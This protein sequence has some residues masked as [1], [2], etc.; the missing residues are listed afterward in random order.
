MTRSLMLA[1]CLLAAGCTAPFGVRH[2]PPEAMH[3]ALNANVLTT[4]ELSNATDIMLRQHDLIEA[5][6][7]DPAGTLRLLNSELQRGALRADDLAALAELSFHYADHGGGKPQFLAA[8]LYAYAFLFPADPRVA[9]DPLDPRLRETADL[10]SRSLTEAFRSADGKQVEIAAGT[11]ALPFGQLDVTFDDQQLR[12]GD[13]RLVKFSPAE[14]L[15]VVGFRNRYRQPGIG[16]PLAAAT[17]PLAPIDPAQPFVVGPHVRVPVTLLLRVPDP[18]Q[19]I[20]GTQ[21]TALL[22]LHPATVA[23]STEIDERTVALAQ[24]PTAALALALNES[25]PWSAELAS[26]LGQVLQTPVLTGKLGG[27][28]PHRQGRIP[29]VLVHGTASNFS[30]WANMVNDLSTD[31]VLREH[32]EFWLFGY[33]SGQPILYSAMQLRRALKD[34]VAAF[35]AADPDPCLDRMVVIGHSQGGLLT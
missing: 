3:R 30:V 27:L 13:R 32:F 31:P 18:R 24:E 1:C 2:R 14:E 15:E 35:Q 12:W 20:R 16:A 19:Q 9:P 11:Y 26:F 28:E 25:Q 10:Y 6:Q 23:M 7:G 21:L 5:Y 33:D 17:K 8:S 22:E 4:G 29:I 34:T